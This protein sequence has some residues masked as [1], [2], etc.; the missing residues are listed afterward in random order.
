MAGT[1]VEVLQG[2][3]WVRGEVVDSKDGGSTY[4]VESIS[5]Q[6]L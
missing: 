1:K 3:K 5:L 4:K 2:G 6:P